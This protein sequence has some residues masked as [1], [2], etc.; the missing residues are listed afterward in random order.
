MKIQVSGGYS[1]EVA[2]E[3]RDN[4]GTDLS[5][6][7]FKLA[8]IPSTVTKGTGLPSA[9]A[10]VWKTPGVVLLP[11]EGDGIS[12]SVLTLG[13]SVAGGYALGKYYAWALY[14]SGALTIPVPAS[15][16]IIELV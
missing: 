4:K 6:V 1:G 8:L 10:A 12:R 3:L 11:G 2:V 5:A 7:S 15:N 9:G 14:T 16:E 13:V